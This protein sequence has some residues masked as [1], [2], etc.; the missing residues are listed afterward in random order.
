[1]GP[2]LE[3]AKTMAE[4]VLIG[5]VGLVVILMLVRGGG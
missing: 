4:Y 5:L 3:F 1:V 2:I